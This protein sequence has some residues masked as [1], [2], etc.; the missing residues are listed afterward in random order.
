MAVGVGLAG[1]GVGVVETAWG[2]E[3]HATANNPITAAN[4]TALKLDM[5][6]QR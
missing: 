3:P 4:R 1:D 5:V 6:L 2:A